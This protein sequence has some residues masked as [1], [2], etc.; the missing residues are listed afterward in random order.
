[1]RQPARAIDDGRQPLMS[2]VMMEKAFNEQLLTSIQM[3]VNDPAG[4]LRA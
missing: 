3:S 2:V 4:E 1:M